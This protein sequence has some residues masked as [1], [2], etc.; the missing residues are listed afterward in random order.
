MFFDSN[1]LLVS[2]LAVA[3]TGG[4]GTA[5]VFWR[6]GARRFSRRWGT[7][8]LFVCAFFA[9]LAWTRFGSRHTVRVDAAGEQASD[10]HRRKVEQHLNFHFSEFFHYYLG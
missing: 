10:P 4:V 7:L 1:Q 9:L 3:L 5:L 2:L 6:S 8:V